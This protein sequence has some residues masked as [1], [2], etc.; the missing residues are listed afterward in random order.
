MV[1]DHAITRLGVIALLHTH[2]DMLVVGEAGHGGEAVDLFNRLRPDLV[3]MNLRMPE[4]D[5]IRATTAILTQDPEA[6]VMLL[7]DH[8]TDDEIRRAFEAGVY[9][10]VPKTADLAELVAA[11]RIVAEG[12]RFVTEDVAQRIRAVTGEPAL[13]AH[14][15]R[16][17]MLISKGLSNHEI[18]QLVT[19]TPGTVRIYVSQILAKLG[20]ANRA[21]AVALALGRGILRGD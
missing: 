21:E 9:G 8:D 4:I 18:A 17:L 20:A 19:L 6:R 14:E 1:D 5:G 15:R 3:L 12:G 10:Y 11:I 7:S 16:I 13:T 2:P